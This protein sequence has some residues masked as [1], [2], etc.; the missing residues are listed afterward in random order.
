VRLFHRTAH[1]E[2]ATRDGFKDGTGF[3]LT[4]DLHTGVWLS[5]RPLDV[6]EGA[7]GDD[8]VVVEIAEDDIAG[9]EWVSEPSF[10]YREWLV[11]S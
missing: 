9:F 6:N 2:D 5:D 4:S 11:R 1:G 8:L 7:E 3:Y 10:G